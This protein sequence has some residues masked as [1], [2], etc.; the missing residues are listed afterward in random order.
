MTFF[1]N[2]SCCECF[3][4]NTSGAG[5]ARKFDYLGHRI[6]IHFTLKMFLSPVFSDIRKS[7]AFFVASH[8]CP[9]VLL[10]TVVLRRRVV[11]DIGRIM[12]TE[13]NRNSRSQTCPSATSTSQG[14]VW[15]RKGSSAVRG[16][17]PTS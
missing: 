8:L 9:L 17:R 13:K 15:D 5:L 3:L 6:R 12:P 11:W 4:F 14:M 10:I 7:T 16:R 1:L 2:P